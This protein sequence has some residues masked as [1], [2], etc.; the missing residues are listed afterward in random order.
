MKNY[1]VS[2]ARSVSSR[3]RA[4]RARLFRE[5]FELSPQTLVLDLGCGWGDYMAEVL[6]FTPVSPENVF[7]ADINEDCVA[8]AQKNHGF[9]GVQLREGKGLDF[10]DKHFDIVF[11]NS[12]I[13]HATLP[14]E[15]LFDVTSERVFRE[16]SMVNQRS[17][18]A[19][20]RRL[21]KGYFVQ[22]PNRWFPVEPHTRLPLMGWMPRPVLIAFIRATRL[23]WSPDWNLLTAS[24]MQELFPDADTITEKFLG[25]RKSI[26]AIKKQP[27]QGI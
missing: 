14:K 8:R 7:A 16:M 26:I 5:S 10:P 20:I 11:S 3:S 24:Q 13:E 2:I 17:F 1:W 23:D 25:M 22:T 12:V 4:E 27:I 9:T 6:A 15:R 18:A 21:G 19:E